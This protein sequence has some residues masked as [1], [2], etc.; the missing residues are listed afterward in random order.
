MD[1]MVLETQQWLNKTYGDDS[2][3]NRVSENGR[4]GWETVYGLT[5]ALQIE[6]GIQETSDNFGPTTMRLCPTLS[7]ES[8]D[9]SPSNY[10]Y[11][12]QGGLWCKGYSPGGFTG[13][14]YKGT[15]S[16]IN[17]FQ[18]DA[19]LSPTGIATPLII[20]ALLNMDAFVLVSG[21][22][23]RIREMQQR[24]N[25]LYNSY[26][27]LMPCDGRY[28]RETNT[29]LVYALQC[30]EGMDTDTANGYFGNGTTS[31][32]PTLSPGDS[33]TNFVYILQ[34][35]LYCNGFN[36]GGFDG[37]YG[38]TVGNAVKS[39]QSFVCLP[40][41]GVANM[42]TIK[43]LL[44]SCG[45]INRAA[46]GCDCATILT[47]AKAATLKNNG[48]TYVGRY[49]TGTIGGGISKALS[50]QEANIILKAGLQ[51]FPIF[52][53]SGY[54]IDYF[55]SSQGNEDAREA[56]DA[57]YRVGIPCGTIIYF[58]VDFDAYD[59]Q[60]TDTIVPYFRA[61]RSRFASYGN[62]YRI[63][64]YG[65]R[66]ICLR[67][68]EAGIS[69]NSFVGD[70]STGYSGNLGYRLPPDWTF[71]QITTV[72]LGSGDG[73]IE[74]D[75]DVASGRGV[76]APVSH[77]ENP[78]ATP[79]AYYSAPV[80]P[81]EAS[82]ADPVDS[83]SGAHT[84]SLTP[85][86]IKGA[87]DFSFQLSYNSSKLASGNVGEGWY[88]NYEMKL[89]ISDDVIYLYRTPSEYIPFTVEDSSANTYGCS[90]LGMQNDILTKNS[91]GSY[92]LNRN[93][94]TKYS[95]SAVGQLINIQNRTG[96]SLTLTHTAD[97]L[98]ITEP[99][100][101]KSITADFN[102]SGLIT[103]VADPQGNTVSLEYDSNACMIALT[104]ANKQKIAYTY[105]DNGR[106]LTGTDGDGICYF[107]NTYDGLG[108]VA[109]QA[110]ANGMKTSFQYD[111]TSADG[112]TVITITDRNGNS[113]KNTFNSLRQL[114]SAVDANGSQK[115][116]IYDANGNIASETDALGY[117]KSTAYD[118]NNRP[119]EQTDEAGLKTEKSYDSQ[120][121][122]LK[123][124][125][126]D[127]S[128]ITYTYDAQN[129]PTSMT[130]ARGTVTA[131]TFMMRMVW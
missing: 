87:I 17:Q 25:R 19:G 15:Q 84:I 47:A 91:D 10:D 35:S 101:G 120:G 100:S 69:V 129:R 31:K 95:F 105:D 104:D 49:L 34:Y 5:R 60:V 76:S 21:G 30:E 37:Q 108:R 16:A 80:K 66:N 68:A 33:R 130:D 59:Y 32:C 103:S 123:Q 64:V 55:S 113:Y 97:S 107:T 79:T 42:P 7:I 20:K 109:T 58:A 94:D 112:Q 116:Y 126:P 128:T 53:T 51:I 125:N 40:V 122:L 6:E 93:N 77:V 73:K 1:E 106:I 3:F 88:H 119:T 102:S 63:G 12:L 26:F 74:I 75:K 48:Y 131:Y 27:G 61:I 110:D 18:S 11:I 29:A 9:A 57:A 85:L 89:S 114:T 96:M 65:A 28:A 8:E 124:T 111:D 54:Y 43:A 86:T 90:I 82:I 118:G 45:D 2:R 39:F 62:P 44:A 70:M 22:D 71:D 117:A 50:A 83:S 67:V 14:F 13:V 127:S 52:E 98:V 99:V 81:K 38:S 36:P 56:M 78:A 46:T 121:N 92:L 115:T 41:T 72:T 23:T 24:L 4:T